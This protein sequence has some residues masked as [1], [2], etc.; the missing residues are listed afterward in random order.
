M[1]LTTTQAGKV[2]NK[3]RFELVR[4]KHHV[5]GFMVV[6]GKKLFPVHY[7]FGRKSMP[8]DI[9]ERFRRSL[10]L[11]TEEFGVLLSCR[12]DYQSYISL[13]RQKGIEGL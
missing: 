5:R 10:Y 3:L 8:G 9:P 1:Q 2:L 6:N 4:C 13:L 11:S 12:M 7:S